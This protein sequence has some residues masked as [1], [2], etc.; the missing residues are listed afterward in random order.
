M[1]GGNP[2]QPVKTDPPAVRT[3]DSK[4]LARKLNEGA[5]KN[6]SYEFGGGRRKFYQER[7]QENEQ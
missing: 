2:E 7:D 5:V 4:T 6:P 1:P 3:I